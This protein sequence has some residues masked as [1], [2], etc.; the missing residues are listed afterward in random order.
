MAVS[1]DFH[2]HSS[3]SGDSDAP[4]ADMAAAAVRLG[5]RD[6]CFT[7][8]MDLD[9]PSGNADPEA[10]PAGYFE[11]NMPEYCKSINQIKASLGDRINIGFGLEFGLKENLEHSYKRIV[12]DYDLDFIIAS[13]HLCDNRDVTWLSFWN[14]APQETIIRRYFETT[15]GLIRRFHDFDVY[16]HLDYIVRYSP[17]KAYRCRD[18]SD[19]IDDILRT[20]I[21]YGKGIEINTKGMRCGMHEM[22]PCR[23][24]LIRYRQLGGEIVTVGSDAHTP[25]DVGALRDEAGEILTSCG[26]RY[27]ATFSKHRPEMHRL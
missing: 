23:D 3:F 22:N 26:F 13:T 27:Y 9:F 6:I 4:M 24:I 12:S 10:L 18:Y 2:M 8:H 20:I 1:S 14:S 7:E 16:G 5:L 15:A 21:G 17:D 25:E 19:I 11:V